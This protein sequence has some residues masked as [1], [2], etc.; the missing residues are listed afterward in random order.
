MSCCY[1]KTNY[2]CITCSLLSIWNEKVN[3]KEKKGANHL[4]TIYLGLGGTPGAFHVDTGRH[5]GT[6]SDT[7]LAFAPGN[8]LLLFLNHSFRDGAEPTTKQKD[9]NYFRH[10]F[11]CIN[12]CSINVSP[13]SSQN[14]FVNKHVCISDHILLSLS[15]IFTVMWHSWP[16]LGP[17]MW[18]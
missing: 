12:H 2:L 9:Y 8:R 5:C 10:A 16:V 18:T 4:P 17:V 14:K 1:N 11:R 15:S 7:G 3:Q 6:H 13:N